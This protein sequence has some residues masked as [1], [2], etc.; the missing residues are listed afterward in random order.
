MGSHRFETEPPL[1]HQQ[2]R[3]YRNWNPP[4]L[5]NLPDDFLRILP[6]QLDCIKVKNVN[7]RMFNWCTW[8]LSFALLILFETLIPEQVYHCWLSIEVLSRFHIWTTDNIWRIGSGHCPFTNEG[9]QEIVVSGASL[10]TGNTLSF[11]RGHKAATLCAMSSARPLTPCE[12]AGQR[13]A[14]FAHVLNQTLNG[15]CTR[16]LAWQSR[17]N[18]QRFAFMQTA[19]QGMSAKF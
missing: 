12:F 11:R 13:P 1:G 7:V 2:V 16:K 5:G 18:V 15:L 9:Q 19:P 8:F 17:F 3:N 6:Q 10:P 4:L 14:L